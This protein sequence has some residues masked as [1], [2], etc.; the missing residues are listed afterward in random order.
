[1]NWFKNTVPRPLLWLLAAIAVVCVCWAI[2]T[3]PWQSPDETQHFGYVQSVAERFALPG[4]RQRLRYSSEHRLADTLSKTGQEARLPGAEWSRQMY[5][6]WKAKNAALPPDARYN[7]GGRNS[8][9]ANPPLYYLYESV[10]YQAAA[11][12]D[13]FNR[14]D[15]MRLWSSLFALATAIGTWL[16]AG[17]VFGRRR[18]LQLA[19]AAVV[20]LQP[21]VVFISSTVNPDGLLIALWTFALW[22]GARILK[23]GLTMLDAV[24]LF[25]VVGLGIVT[26]ATTYALVPAALFVLAV[27]AW[28]LRAAAGRRVALISAVG[29]L[30]LAVPVGGWLAT[31]RALHRPAVNQVTSSEASGSRKQSKTGFNLRGFVSYVRQYYIPK[32]PGLKR[33]VYPA[34]WPAYTV[35]FKGSWGVFGWRQ[36]RL[37]ARVF[38]AIGVA[39]A[40]VLVALA[41][42]FWRRR[43]PFD[44]AVLGF[45][46]LAVLGLLAVLHV[47]E[48]QVVFVN[49]SRADFTQGRYLLPVVSLLGISVAGALTAL[50]RRWRSYAVAGLLGGLLLLQLIALETTARWFYA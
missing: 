23:R 19:A 29:L 36:Y 5:N 26:K 44:G 48:Y 14:L 31:A 24:G 8:A 6:S 28:R 7:G 13:I 50:S 9:A 49:H 3:P 15:V 37:G 34:T 10:A 2:F 43:F 41:F 38:F 40:C 30:A 4:D 16:L 39:A 12:G 46:A 11:G 47:T 1:M 20:G 45:F 21:M 18:S 27:G 33:T 32:L 22:L 25:G 42:A 35:W 17:E